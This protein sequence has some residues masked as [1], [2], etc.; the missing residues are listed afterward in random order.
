MFYM[1]DLF[2]SSHPHILISLGSCSLTC[3]LA[4]SHP[5][6]LMFVFFLVSS[7]PYVLISSDLCTLAASLHPHILR[8]VCACLSPHILL[9][10]RSY[11]LCACWFTHIPISLGSCILGVCW[12]P[13]I[14]TCSYPQCSHLF[15]KLESD[16]NNGFNE[17]ETV[18]METNNDSNKFVTK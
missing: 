17:K 9:T 11:T 5:H 16:K 3:I 8:F 7:H 14:L 13:R 6:I 10:L 12:Y 2:I 1:F 15:R 18:F 4:S